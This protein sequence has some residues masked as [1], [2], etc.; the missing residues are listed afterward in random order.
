MPSEGS[1]TEPSDTAEANPYSAAPSLLGYLAQVEYA[2][3]LTLKRL[4]ADLEF[5]VSIETLDDI[6]FES[7]GEPAELF[8]SKHK[9]ERT[10]SL[11]D[12]STD[13]WK[14]LHNWIAEGPSE[15]SL[16]II[17]NA[18]APD[19]SALSYLRGGSGRNAEA[20]LTRLET[21]ARTSQ[22]KTNK[23][24]YEKFFELPAR[25]P[26]RTLGSRDPY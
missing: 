19:G 11:T 24:Y 15:A 23:S 13:V 21:A 1:G 20:A 6:V 16:T 14:T 9:V 10:A 5:D 7:D 12:K 25:T 26:P 22:S 18:A 4:D 3:L 8:Q 2:L 17:T